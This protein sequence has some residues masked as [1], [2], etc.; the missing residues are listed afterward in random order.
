MTTREG[1][2]KTCGKPFTERSDN[3]IHIPEIAE[4]DCFSCYH[5]KKVWTSVENDDFESVI[6]ED[7]EHHTVNVQHPMSS[8]PRSWLGYSGQLW[9]I[10]FYDGREVRTNNLWRQGNIPEFW[11]ESHPPNARFAYTTGEKVAKKLEL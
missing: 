2:C 8:D 10:Q 6:T 7:F 5:W 11:R 1:N 3:Y 4:G 9:T